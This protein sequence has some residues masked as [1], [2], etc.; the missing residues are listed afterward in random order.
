VVEDPKNLY[1]FREAREVEVMAIIKQKPP[2]N[3]IGW[4]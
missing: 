3:A 2:S 4:H 1:V